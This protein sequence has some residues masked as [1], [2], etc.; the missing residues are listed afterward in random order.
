L[1]SEQRPNLRVP[2]TGVDDLDDDVIGLLGRAYHAN[3]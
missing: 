1:G 3:I 2:L